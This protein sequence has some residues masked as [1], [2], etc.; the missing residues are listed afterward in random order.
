MY[1]DEGETAQ[2][3]VMAQTAK[4]AAVTSGVLTL[5]VSKLI[6]AGMQCIWSMM[7]VLQ[8][9]SFNSLMNV[10][11]KPRVMYVQETMAMFAKVDVM[12]LENWWA[13]NWYFVET[14][15]HNYKFDI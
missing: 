7:A 2:I 12:S 8:E 14:Y 6:G 13:D 3:E 10:S 11:Y 9:I 4:G 5:I 1:I 15:A